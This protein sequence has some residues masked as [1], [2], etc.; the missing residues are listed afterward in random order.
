MSFFLYNFV[1]VYI[2][3]ASIYIYVILQVLSFYP[4]KSLYKNLYKD[5]FRFEDTV[6]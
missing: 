2:L 3:S 5:L 4:I 6:L 1:F